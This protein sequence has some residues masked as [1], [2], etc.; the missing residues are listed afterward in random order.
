L[1]T[2]KLFWFSGL[3]LVIGGG[4]ATTAWLFFAYFDPIHRDH[5]SPMWLPLNFLVIAGG[6]FMALGLTGFY[7]QQARQSGALGL[8][9]FVIFFIGLIVPYVAVQSVQTLTM[10]DIPDGMR[11]LVSVGGPSLLVGSILM[12]IVTWRAGIFPPWVAVALAVAVLLGLFA[13]LVP[14]PPWLGRNVITAVF[15]ITMA[16]IG[17][18][19]MSLAGLTL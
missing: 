2:D 12:A 3:S 18:V 13:Y 7:A 10:P 11:L 9:A 14:L 16:I 4:L 15:T 8:I 19:Q 1:E 5:T 17:A 6:L